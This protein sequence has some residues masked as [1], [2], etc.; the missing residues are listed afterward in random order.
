MLMWMT[1]YFRN[2]TVSF[3][4]LK[5]QRIQISGE[6]VKISRW[7]QFSSILARIWKWK[8]SSKKKR[9]RKKTTLCITLARFISAPQEDCPRHCSPLQ[10]QL[11]RTLRNEGW[12]EGAR[13]ITAKQLKHHVPLYF[14]NQVKPRFP[15]RSKQ[16]GIEIPHPCK[17]RKLM[18]YPQAVHCRD[19]EANLY[20]SWKQEKLSVLKIP[21][22]WYRRPLTPL[23]VGELYIL[24]GIII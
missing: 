20:L 6:G 8:N 22:L 5:G 17:D 18:F 2:L 1:T 24:F 21:H 16:P 14:P 11:L 23:I 15:L 9:K 4:N 13:G 12:T 3:W 10:S 7:V 19:T